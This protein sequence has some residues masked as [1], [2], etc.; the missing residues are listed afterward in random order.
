M[1]AYEILVKDFKTHIYELL[2]IN[3]QEMHNSNSTS[4]VH[5]PILV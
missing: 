5:E 3:V 2:L 1:R 4:T